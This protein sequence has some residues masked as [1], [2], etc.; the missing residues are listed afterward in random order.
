MGTLD[1]NLD[2]ITPEQL[3][4]ITRRLSVSAGSGACVFFQDNQAHLLQCVGTETLASGHNWQG[5][6]TAIRPP[7]RREKRPGPG[8][9]IAP[10]GGIRKRDPRFPRPRGTVPRRPA[11]PGTTSGQRPPWAGRALAGGFGPRLV[12]IP[13]QRRGRVDGPCQ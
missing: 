12:L 6:E 10:L 5:A 3:L 9:A 11:G 1:I 7:A 13:A 8:K 2:I 4:E